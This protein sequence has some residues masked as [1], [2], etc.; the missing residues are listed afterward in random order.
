M[1]VLV[2]GGKRL[3]AC[4]C[5]QQQTMDVSRALVTAGGLTTVVFVDVC[6]WLLLWVRE[7]VVMSRV[8]KQY[9]R[10]VRD[11]VLEHGCVEV[12]GVG[13]MFVGTQLP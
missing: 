1:T 4:A 8:V 5:A 7:P 9:E 11:A 2:D 10:R 3:E 13:G 6:H 12:R